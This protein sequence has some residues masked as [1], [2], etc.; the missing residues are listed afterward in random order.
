[1]DFNFSL[2]E[3]GLDFLRSSLE[4]LTAASAVPLASPSRTN[5]YAALDQKRHLKYALIHLCSSI[6]LILKE[7]LRQ[8]DWRQVFSDPDKADESSSTFVAYAT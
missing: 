3:N 7:R 6:E 1:M 2:L 4:H 5:E 8:E